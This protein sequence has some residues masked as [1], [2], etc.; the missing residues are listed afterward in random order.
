MRRVDG[1]LHGTKGTRIA[2]A[3]DLAR[4]WY[5]GTLDFY[6]IEIAPI[7]HS[8]RVGTLC[9]LR[10]PGNRHGMSTV[11]RSD[12]FWGLINRVAIVACGVVTWTVSGCGG[13]VE[14]ADRRGA[15]GDLCGTRCSVTFEVVEENALWFSSYVSPGG[16]QIWGNGWNDVWA[17]STPT[18]DTMSGPQSGACHFD[19]TNW[20]CSGSDNPLSAVWGMPSGRVFVGGGEGREGEMVRVWDGSWQAWSNPNP[21]FPVGRFAGTSE[22]DIWALDSGPYQDIYTND[23]FTGALAHFD[24]S[25]WRVDTLSSKVR[26][27]LVLGERDVWAAGDSG[28]L[29]HY[30]G[31]WNEQQ[32]LSTASLFGV[33]LSPDGTLWAVGEGF[34]LHWANHIWQT[35][36][37][38]EFS[39]IS[40]VGIWG[41]ASDSIWAIGNKGKGGSGAWGT[42]GA[43]S[44][45]VLRWDGTSWTRQFDTTAPLY[46]IWGNERDVWVGGDQQILRGR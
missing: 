39:D 1:L 32:L 36:L 20:A 6:R 33:W 44:S 5:D 8:W 19:G 35:T 46:S 15:S 4:G 18:W 16:A 28:F 3:E 42:P 9:A 24:G 13:R 22:R 23:N 45:T 40:L 30:D 34:A 12:R 2:S 14:T 41:R 43:T 29:A 11:K 10:A 26:G 25:S 37:P 21:P 31:T 27:F 17:V 38:L 7:R